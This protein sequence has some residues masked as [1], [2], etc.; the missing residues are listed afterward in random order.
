MACSPK[1]PPFPVYPC[2]RCFSISPSCDPNFG[3]V[4]WIL[5]IL[6]LNLD[7]FCGLPPRCDLIFSSISLVE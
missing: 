5:D 7:T 1:T 3:K 2:M 4:I 6:C